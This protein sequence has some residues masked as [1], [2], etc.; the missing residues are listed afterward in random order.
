[1]SL[2]DGT[3]Y[4]VG[5]RLLQRAGLCG[6]E[7]C[8]TSPPLSEGLMRDF[9]TRWE[10]SQNIGCSSTVVVVSATHEIAHKP[11]AYISE[12]VPYILE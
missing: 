8:A 2:L 4:P 9:P 11:Q 3:A 5:S 7:V 1:M 12:L 6:W 10:D